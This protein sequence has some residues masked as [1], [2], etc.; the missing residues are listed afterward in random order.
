MPA[1][2]SHHLPTRT[3]RLAGAPVPTIAP[4]L[5]GT[6]EL[7][8]LQIKKITLAQGAGLLAIQRPELVR[9]VGSGSASVGRLR[10]LSCCLRLRVRTPACLRRLFGSC[11]CH[12]LRRLRVRGLRA[13]AGASACGFASGRLH[14]FLRTRGALDV[15]RGAASHSGRFWRARGLAAACVFGTGFC[16]RIRTPP[17]ASAPCEFAFSTCLPLSARA[18][19]QPAVECCTM[20]FRTLHV[21]ARSVRIRMF[22]LFVLLAAPHAPWTWLRS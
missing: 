11:R 1:Q 7:I 2:C 21:R 17:L 18:N 20:R 5:F 4:S 9:I 13:V 16:V 12:V 8:D 22:A 10:F 14:I 15:V 6:L 3:H 19:S